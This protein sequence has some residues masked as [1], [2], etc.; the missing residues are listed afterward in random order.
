MRKILLVIRRE[1]LS[2]IKKKSFW[3]IAAIIPVMIVALYV[4]PMYF[5]S[6]SMEKNNVIV[7]D[8]TSLFKAFRSN[9][10]IQYFH[11]T[12]LDNA[13][14]LLVDSDDAFDAI[15]YIPKTATRIPT[16]AY[17]YY[18]ADAP[19]TTVKTDIETQLQRI[20][21]NNILL[22]IHQISKSD[23]EMINNSIIHLH[24][25]DLETGRTDF[26]ELK[27]VIG[28]VL[29][30]LIYLIIFLF[31][32]QVIRGI[33]EEKSNRIIEVMASTVSPFQLMM[34]KIVGIAMAG[35]TQFVLWVMLSF[36]LFGAIRLV[37]NDFLSTNTVPTEVATIA[38][39]G[40]AAVAQ[41]MKPVQKMPELMEGLLSINFGVIIGL[42]LL[43]FIL[44]YLLYA[45]LFA[46]AGSITESESDSQQF[47]LLLTAPLLICLLLGHGI[48]SAPNGSLAVWLSMIPFTSP[49]AMMIRIPFGFPIWQMWLSVAI[50]VLSFLL[51]AWFA[52]KI[53]KTGILMYGKK[54]SLKQFLK[55]VKQ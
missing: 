30:I 55:W 27:I 14:A 42:F 53:Y 45:S 40:D 19:G 46:A 1:Y 43:Y 52:G 15:V 8:E 5:S 4:V 34:G 16:D 35:I 11:K 2:R 41:A 49:V 23:F 38:T 32:S 6:K 47:I 44:G 37:D 33:V 10:K 25:K 28:F 51:S 24:L 22:E 39:K 3:F 26:L 36:L 17:L 21:K 9:D 13:K 12:D 50:L 18:R 54:I 48:I 29:G 31:G 20:L 7:V